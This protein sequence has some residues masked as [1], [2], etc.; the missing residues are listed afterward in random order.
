MSATV[1]Y[2]LVGYLTGNAPILS[3][4]T[5]PRSQVS[6]RQSWLIQ[7]GSDLS[8]RQFVAGSIL[9]GLVG[10]GLLWAVA[11]TWW[12]ALIPAVVIAFLPYAY[13]ARQRV[14]RLAAVQKAWPDGLREVL[15]HV[16][17]GATL[18]AA[19]EALST[20]GPEALRDAFT[21]FP[22]QTR[23][24][25]VIPALEIVKEE[26]SDPA[27]DK[28][29]EV[30]ILAHQFG[31]DSLQTVL[32]DLIETMTADELTAEQIRTAGFEQKL[33]GLVVAVA[34]WLILLFLATVPETY[35]EFYR[36]ATGRFVVIVAG[37]WAAFGWL[38]MR[39]ISKPPE[40]IRVFGGGS[41]LGE[42]PGRTMP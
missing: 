20:R 32:R 19:V 26:L 13:F 28:V 12:V 9:S 34:P 15:A 40:E 24:F 7:A 14:Q 3:A 10:L 36:T 16:S 6:S 33:E 25:G 8:P 5:K 2:L 39:L 21:R 1:V 29:I 30:L 31:G 27:S 41:T 11:G 22:A 35:R 4:R 37:I 18:T 38:L 42:D 23:M 17:S